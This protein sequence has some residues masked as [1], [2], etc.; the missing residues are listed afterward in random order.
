MVAFRNSA[1]LPKKIEG[2]LF[3][4]KMLTIVVGFHFIAYKIGF[5]TDPVNVHSPAA[6]WSRMLWTNQAIFK[7]SNQYTL[8]LSHFHY[9]GKTQSEFGTQLA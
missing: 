6:T 5:Y 1:N 8:Q 3:L 2:I 7:T 9:N 4:F